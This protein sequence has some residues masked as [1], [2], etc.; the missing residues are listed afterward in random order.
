MGMFLVFRTDRNGFLTLRDVVTC[1]VGLSYRGMVR[2]TYVHHA[3]LYLA[4]SKNMLL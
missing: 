2:S 4:T 1:R 3:E